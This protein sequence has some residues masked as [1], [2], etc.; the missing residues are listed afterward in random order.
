MDFIED[1]RMN[2]LFVFCPLCGRFAFRCRRS[3][4]EKECERCKNT[5]V[6][7]A[8]DESLTVFKSRRKNERRIQKNNI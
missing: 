3:D 4:V 6:I 1:G 5:L 8:K 2:K 7:S